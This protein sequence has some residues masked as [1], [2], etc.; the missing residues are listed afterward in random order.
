[1]CA[2][3]RLKATVGAVLAVGFAGVAPAVAAEPEGPVVTITA[4][5]D[6]SAI[7]AASIVVTG[8]ANDDSGVAEVRVQGSVAQLT[9]DAFTV[10]VPAAVGQNTIT[11]VAVDTL[12]NSTTVTRTVLRDDVIDPPA[13][14]KPRATKLS[15]ARVGKATYIRFALESGAGR[16]AVRLWRQVPHPGGQPTWT[17]VTALRFA[18]GTPGLRRLLLSARR[19]PTGVYQVRLSTVAE[20]GVSITTLRFR[21]PRLPAGR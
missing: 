8:T 4:P 5:V 1:M 18:A 19:I 15:I 17:P 11:I 2:V 20:G 6:G 10:E 3:R 16:V 9:G 13:A 14:P 7:G 12:G 21:V